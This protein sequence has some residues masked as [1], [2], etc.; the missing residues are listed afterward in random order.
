MREM[1]TV[2][3]ILRADQPVHHGDGNFG[4]SAVIKRRRFQSA[5]GSVRDVPYIS[6]T[7][8]AHHLREAGS[9]ALLEAA[10]LLEDPQLTEAA[11][12]LLLNGGQVKGSSKALTRAEADELVELLPHIALLGGCVGNTIREGMTWSDSVLLVCEETAPFLPEWVG[13]W[14]EEQGRRLTPEAA[15]IAVE[16]GMRRTL[17]DHPKATRLLSSGARADMDERLAKRERASRDDDDAAKLAAKSDAMI[18]EYETVIMGS[19]WYWRI[20]CEVWSAIE[21]DAF[22]V[23]LGAYLANPHIGG[24][25]KRGFGRVS[26]VE[27]RGTSLPTFERPDPEAVTINGIN[28]PELA[29]YVAHVSERRERIVDFLARVV[30]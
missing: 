3:L 6:G 19:L 21:R 8:M 27:M 24:K 16:E 14:L 1:L 28:S 17:D 30:A 2:E 22:W 12:R 9:Y 4:N 20:A 18:F 29:R 7:S 11:Q 25:S 23:M 15:L 13:T 10:G 5:D 26:V